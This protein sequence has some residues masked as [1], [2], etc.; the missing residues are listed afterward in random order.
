MGAFDTSMGGPRSDLPVTSWATILR[1]GKADDP[2]SREHLEKLIRRYWKPVFAYIRALRASGVEQ[3]K[4]LTQ[5]YFTH[6]LEKEALSGLRPER[7]SFR[8]FL[9]RS[10]RNFVVDA[11]RRER[12]RRPREGAWLFPLEEARDLESCGAASDDAEVQFERAWNRAV[13]RSAVEDLRAQLQS[14]GLGDYF[15]LFEKYFLPRDGPERS[16]IPT[17]HELAAE[18]G[19][20]ESGVRKRL[21][22]CTDALRR[23]LRARIREYASEADDIEAEVRAVLA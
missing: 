7:G 14:E 3:A 8:G 1:A 18:A 17:H 5:A 23:N 15:S 9:R 6:L 12:A 10:I 16:S 13:L 11:G 21:A 2:G 19:L 20:S 4:D 22:Y